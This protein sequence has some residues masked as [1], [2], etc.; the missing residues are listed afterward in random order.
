MSALTICVWPFK[1]QGLIFQNSQWPKI[2]FWDATVFD[3]FLLPAVF[4]L[5]NGI[6][7]SWRISY[8][9][10][11]HLIASIPSHLSSPR[12]LNMSPTTALS[13]D[14]FDGIMRK[15][16]D[17]GTSYVYEALHFA[18]NGQLWGPNAYLKLKVALFKE[19]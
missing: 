1:G 10:S 7:L 3:E 14:L 17:M 15:P 6:H 9:R 2:Y 5:F 16:L 12:R 4:F 8:L 11:S 19:V 13:T 18:S